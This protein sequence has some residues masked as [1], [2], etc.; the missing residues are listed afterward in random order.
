MHPVVV[1]EVRVGSNND[2]EADKDNNDP[3]EDYDFEISRMDWKLTFSFK[4]DCSTFEYT[5]TN[6]WHHP[7][8]NW[9]RLIRCEK[10]EMEFCGNPYAQNTNYVT[11]DGIGMCTF[12]SIYCHQGTEIKSTFTILHHLLKNQL[13][14]AIN[15]AIAKDLEFQSN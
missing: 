10:I 5:I 2:E 4:F 14:N 9:L 15:C 6:P 12:E 7:K 1:V 13:E 3:S 11:C 8:N